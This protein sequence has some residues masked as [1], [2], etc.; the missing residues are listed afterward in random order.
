MSLRVTRTETS[1]LRERFVILSTTYKHRKL[2]GFTLVELLTVIAIIGVLA[3][4]VLPA[5][6]AAREAAR[7]VQCTSSIRQLAVAMTNF[8]YSYKRYPAGCSRSPSLTFNQRLLWT[9]H[10]L[11]FIE[12]ST[13]RAKIDL[14]KNW[15]DPTSSNAKALQFSSPIFRCPSA[16]APN[17]FDHE[18]LGRVPC[19]YLAC[20][21]GLTA[22]ETGSVPI[23]DDT[24]QDGVF[25]TD[26]ET[27]HAGIGD[28]TSQTILVGE[29]LFLETV[30]GL[31][32]NNYPQLIDH[33]AVGSPTIGPSELSEALGS[34]ACRMNAWLIKPQVFIEEIELGFSS[35]HVGGAHVVFADGHTD[36]ISQSIDRDA[37]SAMGTRFGSDFVSS[38]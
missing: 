32:N 37:W 6:Q 38:Y 21:S 28:G 16:N 4:L 27:T 5:I 18:I 7:R 24:E 36:F 10:I 29:A 9:G 34:T 12:Q 13:V 35:R 2:A 23:I 22:R 33:W 11:P 17:R 26:S 15:E 20:A 3:S 1:A 31:D 14:E 25:Y 19:T 30:S 8:E